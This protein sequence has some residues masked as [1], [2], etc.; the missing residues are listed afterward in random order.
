M[1]IDFE[2]KVDRFVGPFI[3][4]VLSLFSRKGKDTAIT[5]KPKNILTILLSEMGSLVLAQPMFQHIRTKYPEASLYALLFEKNKEILEIFNVVPQENILTVSN[6][7]MRKFV[8]DSL[9]VIIKMRKFGIDTI[10]DCELFMRSSSIYSFMSGAKTLVG[11]HPYTQEGLF[12]G[13]FINRPVL[14]NPYQH[15]SHQFITL[16]EAIESNNF[17]TVK[18]PVNIEPF[19]MPSMQVSEGEIMDLLKR[20]KRD[21]PQVSGKKLVLINPSGGLLPIRAWPLQYF[22]QLAEGLVRNGYIV[23]IIGMGEDKKIADSIVSHCSSNNCVDLTGY[24][25]SV[26]ELMI[27]FHFASLLISN[28]GG[29]GHFAAA[30]PISTIVFFGPETPTLYGS[31]D[32]NAVNYYAHLSCSPCLTA[33]NHR[34][35]PC[36]GDNVCLQRIHP[37]EVLAKSREILESQTPNPY[38]NQINDL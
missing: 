28:D 17:P 31:L 9:N 29:P 3:C 22:C 30:T 33:Y 18:R 19:K 2:R 27:M 36:N 11:F 20:F 4:R 13:D 14:Y 16:V 25:Q 35:S 5:R 24:T 26:R 34:N 7:S 6:A 21:F 8:R 32:E 1:D 37:E 23:G 12:R 10:I 15:I 38:M